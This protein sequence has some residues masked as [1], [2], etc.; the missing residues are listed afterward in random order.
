MMRNDDASLRG[1]AVRRLIACFLLAAAVLPMRA[2][3]AAKPTRPNVVL[4]LSDDQHWRDYAFL[5]HKQ[6]RTPAL[7]R[8]A[9][10][11]LVFTRGYVPSS[12]CCPSLAS[13]ITG[14]YPHE[15]LITG[16]D[17]PEQAG[18]PRRS[19]AGKKLFEQGRE[20][21]NQRLERWPTLPKLLGDAGYKSLQT[22]KWWQGH[23]SR[24][25]F[26]EGMTKGSRHGDEGLAI[27]RKTMQP[28]Y[29]FI[30]RCSEADQPFFVWYAPMLPHDPHDPGKELVTH[31]QTKT[32]SVHV[33]RYWGNV[34]RFDQTVGELVGYLDDNDLSENTLIV[35]VC[36]N[37]WIT[38]AQRGSFAGKSKLSPYDGGLRT[39]IMLRQPGRIEP[40]RSEALA[41]S[42]DLLPT[43][44][45]SC[46]VPGPADL[47]G[48]DLLDAKAVAARKQLFG[49]CYQH[50]LA[51]LDKPGR[52]LL[53]RWTVK[54][55]PGG[56]TWKLIEP[57]T[58]G[59]PGRHPFP[60][61]EEKRVDAVSKARF[62]TGEIELFNVAVDPDET[63]NQ[64]AAHP[65]VVK[66]LRADLDGWW[67]PAVPAAAAAKAAAASRRLAP[68][69]FSRVGS[70][71]S[72]PAHAISSDVRSGHPGPRSLDGNFASPSG[73]RSVSDAARLVRARPSPT[74]FLANAPRVKALPVAARR[75][76]KGLSSWP[77]WRG[78]LLDGVAGGS[79]YATSW[80]PTENVRWKVALPGLG[81]STPV[82]WGERLVLTCGIDGHDGVICFDRAG[83]ELWRQQLG[84]V[85]PGKHKK[86]TGCNSSPVTD[87][88]HVW[89]YFKSGELA[90]LSLATGAVVWKTNLQDRFGEDT[91]WWDL[92]TSPVLTD[93]A[94]VVAVMQ[95]GPSYLAAFDRLTGEL[96][97][98]H[99][100]M[101]DAPEEAA[102]SY[103]TP[104]V[105]TGNPAW[106]EPAEMLVVLG[107]DHVTAHDAVD[108]REHW[109][110]GGLNPTGHKFFR[111][112]ASPVVAGE[113]VIAPYA[114]GKSVTVI[115]RGGSGDV[116]A[117]HVAWMR[118]PLGAD[119]PTPAV[120]D[121][122]MVI[123][124]DKG[125]VS[126]LDIATGKTFW[127][128][129]LPKNR[130]AYSASPVIV[131]GRVMLTRE[132]GH[133]WLLA[134]PTEA[135][136]QAFTVVGE[137][138][139]DEMTV[140]TPVCVDGEIFLRT[141]DSLWCIHNSSGEAQ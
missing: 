22:G 135:A 61:Y 132:D 7:D 90:C 21:M 99:D 126:C 108:G 53:W 136:D 25:G 119:V 73:L 100:R 51:D 84:E 127:E 52:N 39:P 89:V 104:V 56:E 29:D 93:T 3:L 38:D 116:T 47:P 98:K 46:K 70:K 133:A 83:K 112:I 40:G 54:D 45:K 101:L 95:T 80:S 82:V 81:A 97:W 66:A 63:K 69:E 50:T 35:Y 85:R 137:G 32:D 103:S 86:A 9:S 141:H 49:A 128:G 30:G 31:Y 71:A 18:V 12:L 2:A 67:K 117:S 28:V 68:Q 125:E 138:T 106:R 42:L 34:E 120:R 65:D 130:N 8:L 1:L 91:L 111:S 72:G 115:R 94:V 110:V 121:G 139:V 123:A 19:P 10:E 76:A 55:M 59:V 74:Q 41:S 75:A 118:E 62:E 60:P 77:N 92:G 78:P 140:A 5:G 48:I 64:A 14:H 36:D 58:H 13:L 43:I 44:L 20:A 122:R 129:Q 124:G 87:G 96:L 37:G 113:Y 16:N 6:L 79:G 105:L 57:V 4:I 15:H 11:S 33:A 17:P 88:E 26:D 134:W 107:A 131:D 24:G 114:R 109:R 27:G 102:Q 23:Y